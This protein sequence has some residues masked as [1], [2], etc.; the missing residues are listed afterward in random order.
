MTSWKNKN[1]LGGT[2]KHRQNKFWILSRK[3]I[4]KQKPSIVR[5]QKKKEKNH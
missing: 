5:L 4:A 2:K 1:K 3:F